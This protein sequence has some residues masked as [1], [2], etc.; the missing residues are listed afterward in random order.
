VHDKLEGLP[1]RDLIG[2]WVNKGGRLLVDGGYYAAVVLLIAAV[3][4]VVHL[5]LPRGTIDGI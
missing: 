1:A 3:G 4:R 5:A 2:A